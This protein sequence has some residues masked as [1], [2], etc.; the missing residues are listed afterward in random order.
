MDALDD[1]VAL[2]EFSQYVFRVL[3]ASRRQAVNFR[4]NSQGNVRRIFREF[5]LNDTVAP[6]ERF[7]PDL[8]WALLARRAR[9][10]GRSYQ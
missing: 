3:G 4:Q 2:A 1:V 8:H 10:T 7:N 6:A 9:R 5:L